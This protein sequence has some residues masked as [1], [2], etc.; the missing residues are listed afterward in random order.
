MKEQIGENRLGYR[1]PP[2]AGLAHHVRDVGVGPAKAGESS[3]PDK[4]TASGDS[5]RFDFKTEPNIL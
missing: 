5:L 2:K 1:V 4:K 3:H